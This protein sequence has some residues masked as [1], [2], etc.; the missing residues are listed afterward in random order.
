MDAIAWM[1]HQENHHPDMEIGYNYCVVKYQT[2]A[3][4]GLT[5]NDFI[6]AA[7]VDLLYPI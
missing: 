2:H 1:A 6:C 7:K 3:V 4:K 5:P